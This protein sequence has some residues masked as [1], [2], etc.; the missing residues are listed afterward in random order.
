MSDGRQKSQPQLSVVRTPAPR[1]GQYVRI[2]GRE[3]VFLILR[4]DKTRHLAD[5]LR[6]GA[7]RKVEGGVPLALLRVVPSA[8]TVEDLSSCEQAS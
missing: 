4:V 7:V 2:G 5:L 6:R 3:E 1:A 8:K